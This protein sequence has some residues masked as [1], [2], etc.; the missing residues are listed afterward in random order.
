MAIEVCEDISNHVIVDR[1]PRVPTAYADAFEPAQW[2]KVRMASYL[3]LFIYRYLSSIPFYYGTCEDCCPKSPLLNP[4]AA[5][6]GDF[7][8]DNFTKQTHP[9][10]CP[11]GPLS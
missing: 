2:A 11:T 10:A 5:L 6:A 8:R 9:A 4:E 7:L 3:K 1:A